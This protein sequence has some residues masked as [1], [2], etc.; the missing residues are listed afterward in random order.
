MI[1]FFWKLYLKVKKLK[2]AGIDRHRREIQRICG[3]QGKVDLLKGK[4]ARHI[5]RTVNMPE[6]AVA[7]TVLVQY[8]DD[9]ATHKAVPYRRKMQKN[10]DRQLR[11]LAAQGD[12]GVK[13]QTQTDHLAVDDLEII[14]GSDGVLLIFLDEPSS[15]SANDA[16]LQT[17][18]VVVKQADASDLILLH[19]C[20]HF[21][22]G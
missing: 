1:G 5:V 15:R 21:G 16:I 18:C 12:C 2:I 14:G 13:A 22:G 20:L 9:L 11:V 19:H 8:V 6:I 7:N 4:A 3:S 10:D 17:I